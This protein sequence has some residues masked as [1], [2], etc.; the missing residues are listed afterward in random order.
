MVVTEGD[1]SIEAL[2]PIEVPPQ[3]PAYHAQLAPAPRLPPVTVRVAV[4]PG[5][6]EVRLAEVPVGAV[7]AVFTVIVLFVQPVVLQIP[8]AR[9]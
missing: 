1:T 2:L 5:Q 8:T 9:T 4:P 3:L 6:T 7:D